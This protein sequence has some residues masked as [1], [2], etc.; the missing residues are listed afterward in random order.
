MMMA[1]I[2]KYKWQFVQII[3]LPLLA[4]GAV[5]GVLAQ[6]GS[7]ET[8]EQKAIKQFETTPLQ[9]MNLGDHIFLFSGD[10]GNV[11]A[12]VGEGDTLLVDSGMATRT[13]E[14]SEAIY[15]ATARPVTRL[16]NTHWHLDHTG[17]NPYFGSGGVTIIA[18]ENVKKSLTSVQSVS[19]VGFRDGHYPEMALPTK[20]YSSSL[21]L[22]QGSQQLNLV[23]YG[24]AHTDGDSIIYLDP[25]NIVIVG[26]IFSN[27]FYP[28]IDLGSGGSIDGLIHSVDEVLAHT[29]EQT[30]V[31]PGHGPFAT[32]ADLRAY[33]EMLAHVRKRVQE[34]VAAGR[35]MNQT[36]AAAPT[37]EFDA[38]WG[39]GY[40]S[41]NVFTEMVYSSLKKG[42]DGMQPSSGSAN[43]L[44]RSGGTAALSQVE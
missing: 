41:G 23:N 6:S 42:N 38:K 27:P 28:V 34:L 40:L 20:T 7:S 30:K 16:I 9:V 3:A 22:H 12:V 37:S 1:F 32:R 44:P 8:V 29:N 25:A 15:K 35:T 4:G 11:V 39:N 17:G 18:Q 36:A 2:Q 5:S 43:S 14:L 21:T 26:D 31:I 24:S 19:F 10:G 33:R 13:S